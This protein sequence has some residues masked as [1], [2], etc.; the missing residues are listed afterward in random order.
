MVQHYYAHS[1]QGRPKSKWQRLEA[2]LGQTARLASTFGEPFGS[3]DWT[4]LA[5]LWHDLGKYLPEFQ[6]KMDHA[7][8]SKAEAHVDHSIV[9]AKL[10]ESR[11]RGEALALARQELRIGPLC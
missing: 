11:G 6:R 3:A 10:A 5:G 9:G 1:L 4:R 8:T 2:H 7:G